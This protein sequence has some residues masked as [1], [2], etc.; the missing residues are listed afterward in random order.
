MLV[1]MTTDA[2]LALAPGIRSHEENPSYRIWK[3]NTGAVGEAWGG[4]LLPL[5]PTLVCVLWLSV[6]L[7]V[8]ACLV[9]SRRQLLCDSLLFPGLVS[10]FVGRS[11]R[12]SVHTDVL[13][14]YAHTARPSF[15]TAG[16]L[17]S[18]VRHHASQLRPPKYF[19]TIA[20]VF[21]LT[22][23]RRPRPYPTRP[24]PAATSQ[25]ARCT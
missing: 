17:L 14:L 20:N 3:R 8:S 16:P 7:A 22:F 1:I 6:G 5:P 12:A 4:A 21:P 9:I 25:R 15:S 2:E 13:P 10:D 23:F 18:C 24:H 11:A 19:S